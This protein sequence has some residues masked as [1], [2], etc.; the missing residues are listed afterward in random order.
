M[1]P[2]TP[3]QLLDLRAQHEPLQAQLDAALHA[4]L[5]EAAFIQGEAVGQFA[6]ELGQYL[7]NPQ[8]VPCANGTDALQLALLSLS[9]PPGT[10]VLMPAFTYVATW[11]AAAVLGLVPVPVEVSPHTY[12]L[13]PAAT[14]AAITPRTG[15]ILAVHL[16]G[17]CADLEALRQL[18]NQHGVA[19]IEDNAQAIGATFTT[20]A[21]EV[22]AAG[23]VGEVGTTSFFPSKNLGGFGDGGALF[24]RDAAR[25]QLLRQL[26]N[27]G[28]TRKYHHERIGLNSRLD[29]LQAAL[30]RVKLP[31]LGAWTAARQRIA[32]QY[33]AALLGH[34]SLRPPGRDPRSSHVFHQYTV[35]VPDVASQRDKLQ[36]YLTGHGIP[37]AVYYPLPNHLQPAYA[38]LGYSQGQFPVAE[39]LARTVLSVPMHPMLTNEQVAYI[40]QVLQ[41]WP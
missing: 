33:D 5:Q 27:H 14:A 34:S 31:H 4:T 10:E 38:Y 41:A 17:Q 39:R 1:Q 19:L 21:G 9:L 40:C 32:A 30:L 16:F 26:A 6:I 3:I 36:H 25:A 18:A 2:P 7:G 13:D 37:S 8:V 20:A 35:Q 15:A 24:T 22:W 23:T 29:T 12:N 11:E 28:Q